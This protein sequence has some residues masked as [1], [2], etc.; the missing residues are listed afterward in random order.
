MRRNGPFSK[1]VTFFCSR[2]RLA[3]TSNRNTFNAIKNLLKKQYKS[4]LTLN[5]LRYLEHMRNLFYN[6]PILPIPCL[7]DIPYYH[8]LHLVKDT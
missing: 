8:S 5:N 1:P 7:D 4:L 3:T 6:I 2:R